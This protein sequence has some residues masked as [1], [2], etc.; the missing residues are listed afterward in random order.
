MRTVSCWRRM[1]A[2]G[3]VL[4]L[5]LFENLLNQ[6]GEDEWLQSRCSTNCKLRFLQ[7]RRSGYTMMVDFYCR[8]GACVRPQHT[9]KVQ[10]KWSF[11]SRFSRAFG[12][13]FLVGTFSWFQVQLWIPVV[14]VTRVEWCRSQM[15]P[16]DPPPLTFA[17]CTRGRFPRKPLQPQLGVI[18]VET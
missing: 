3:S 16:G 18:Q 12:R 8:D 5:S 15:T 17:P 10:A 6:E 9:T 11:W 2:S 14:S 7:Y 4:F 1:D 13:L